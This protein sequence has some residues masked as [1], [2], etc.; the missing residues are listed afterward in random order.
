MLSNIT[1]KISGNLYLTSLITYLL[2][3]TLPFI[4]QFKRLKFDLKNDT[5]LWKVTFAVILWTSWVTLSTCNIDFGKFHFPINSNILFQEKLPGQRDFTILQGQGYHYGANMFSA[6]LSFI[7]S[8]PLWMTERYLPL[9][10]GWTPFIFI[11]FIA[12]SFSEK[13]ALKIA[14]L[15][16]FGINIRAW[17]ILCL[18]LIHLLN[19]NYFFENNSLELI[20]LITR[21]HDLHPSIFFAP[22]DFL[23]LPG[24]Y[25]GGPILFFLFYLWFNS[26]LSK[27]YVLILSGCLT[28]CQALFREDYV[29]FLFISLTAFAFL[30]NRNILKRIFITYLISLTVILTQ[31]GVFSEAFFSNIHTEKSIDMESNQFKAGNFAKIELSPYPSLATL[32]IDKGRIKKSLFHPQIIFDAFLDL[33]LFFIYFLSFFKLCNNKKMWLSLST[34]IFIFIPLILFTDNSSMSYKMDLQRII[35]YQLII[36]TILIFTHKILSWKITLFLIFSGVLSGII[37]P[38]RNQSSLNWYNKD[39]PKIGAFIISQTSPEKKHLIKTAGINPG[40][41]GIQGYAFKEDFN[42]LRGN[43]YNSKI[44]NLFKQINLDGLKREGIHYV[45]Y[46]KKEIKNITKFSTQE[47]GNKVLITLFNP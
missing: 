40:Y 42:L 6:Q 37:F 3:T 16:F 2:L 20:R 32:S 8:L 10:L 15:A 35:P 24:S 14:L 34:P 38:I 7:S 1:L 21:D 30:Y 4:G 23:L 17:F 41:T 45:I 12:K 36:L 44:T 31:G 5:I 9:V 18:H 19:P 26:K 39:D 11:F 13:H 27:A 46:D 33:P 43:S 22:Q 25:L 47:F 28:C 29:V